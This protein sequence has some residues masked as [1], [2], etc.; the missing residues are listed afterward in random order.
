MCVKLI[1]F[2]TLR[3]LEQNENRNF[4]LSDPLRIFGY[5][6]IFGENS[7]QPVWKHCYQRFFVSGSNQTTTL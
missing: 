2:E 5:I 6:I 1:V 7:S 3:N 4:K